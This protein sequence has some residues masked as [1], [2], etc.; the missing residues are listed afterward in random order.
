MA[1]PVNIKDLINGRTV[2]WERIEFKEGWNPEPTLK[3]ICGFANDFNNWGGGYIVVGIQQLNGRPVLPPVGLDINSID[4]IQQE[5]NNLCRRITPN[6]F[7]VVEPVDFQDKKILILWCPGG[8]VRP[9]KAPDSLGQNPQYFHFIRKN[10]LT[11]RPTNEEERELFS[12]ADRI[13]FDDQV[14]HR[15]QLTDFDQSVIK[16]YLTDIG[17]DLKDQLVN[18]SVSQIARQMNIAEG[19]DEHL[20]PKNIGLLFFAKN[21]QQFFPYAKIEIVTFENE[22]GDTFTEKIFTG[23]LHSQLRSALEYLKDNLV[24]EKISKVEGQAESNRFFNYPYEAIEEALCNA[25]YHRGYDDD[26]TIEVRIYPQYLNIISYPGP[27]LPLDKQK[28]IDQQFDV[29][30]YRNRR[31]GEFLKELHLTEGRATGVPTIKSSLERN[32]SPVPIFET[33][34]QRTY[35]KTTLK[36][37]PGFIPTVVRVGFNP[38]IAS[39]IGIEPEQHRNN[40]KPIPEKDQVRVQVSVQAN[41]FTINNLNEVLTLCDTFGEQAREQVRAQAEEQVGTQK[42]KKLIEI[43]ELCLIPRRREAIL[44]EFGLTNIF[45][46][47][48]SHILVLINKKLLERTVPDKPNSPSQK[49]RTTEKG[50]KL[51]EILR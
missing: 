30:K 5:L 12:M 43:L 10:S 24:V 29:R 31:I 28:L 4:H 40:V 14:N 18:L 19:A 26:S 15:A 8:S 36:I 13:P 1:L 35:F 51:L 7:P 34:D 16:N 39:T 45:K 11:V 48:K 49:Y 50:K 27:L 2:E 17:S 42:L 21:T 37:H 25:V 20:L 44:K 22:L 47:Y 6:Y 23:N 41:F 33:D 9:Y 46:N 32:G 3:T 38:H